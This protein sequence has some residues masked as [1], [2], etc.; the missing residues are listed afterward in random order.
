MINRKVAFIGSVG[1]GKSTI[2]NHLSNVDVIDTD[3]ESTIDIGKA[4]TTVGIDYGEIRIDDQLKLSLY[5]V[6]GQRKFSFMWD[7]VKDGLWG[8]V[9]LVKN[10]SNES[11]EELVFLLDYFDVQESN[12]CLIGITH[13]DQSKGESTKEK[14]KSI[15]SSKNLKL[16]IYSLDGRKKENAELIFK[17]LI[18]LEETNDGTPKIKKVNS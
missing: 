14:I 2:I 4:K 6:P 7:F 12:S 17:T 8:L 13:T 1:S 16:P 5:G 18:M 10:N 3:V 11:L 9:I 15:L